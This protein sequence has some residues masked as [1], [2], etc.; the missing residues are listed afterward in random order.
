MYFLTQAVVACAALPFLV[1]AVPVSMMSARA[2]GPI[3]MPLKHHPSHLNERGL[4]DLRKMQAS[5][6]SDSMF[7]SPLLFLR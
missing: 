4:V 3:L 7:V 1:G 5:I 6:R 2:G